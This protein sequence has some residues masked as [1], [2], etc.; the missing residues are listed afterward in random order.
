M[1]CR[2]GCFVK[3]RFQ[4]QDQMFDGMFGQGNFF[5]IDLPE[6]CPMKPLFQRKPKLIG[7]GLEERPGSRVNDRDEPRFSPFAANLE[8]LAIHSFPGGRDQ[9]RNA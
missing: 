8:H 2:W 4:G 9:F 6:Q 1:R 3:M 7:V 5:V